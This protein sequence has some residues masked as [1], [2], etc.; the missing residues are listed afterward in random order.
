MAEKQFEEHVYKK[1]SLLWIENSKAMPY[2]FIV[3]SGQLRQ[4]SRIMQSEEVVV[5]NAGDTFGL[6][7]CLTGHEYLNKMEALT[8]TS[9]VMIKQQY[10]IPFLSSKPDIFLKITSDYSNRLRHINQRL[11]TLCSKSLYSEMPDRLLEVAEYFKKKEQYAA[12][13]LALTRYSEYTENEE[14][15]AKAL[16]E[17]ALLKQKG[18]KLFEPQVDGFRAIY[19]RDQIIFLEQERGE[20][21]YF[22]EKGKVKISHIDKDNEFVVAVLK[23][24][25][26]FGEMALL[27]QV[28]RTA[29]AIAFEDTRLLILHRDTFMH[30]VAPQIL[31][32]IFTSLARRIWYSYRRA[33]NLSYSSPVA[34]LYDSLDLIIQSKEGKQKD[35]SYFFDI[36]FQELKVMTNTTECTD[37]ELREFLEDSNIRLGGGSI[38]IV[39]L[40]R[41]EDVYKLHLTREKT[42]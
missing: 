38:A 30:Q 16:Q 12:C 39:N 24:G 42:K 21:F 13:L 23:E 7:E 1:G 34:R 28:A 9:V 40:N 15:K 36:T 4:T 41:F 37:N 29:T 22:I 19:P 20:Q 14:N 26:F 35:I 2:F 11:F 3:K 6:T 31:N 33:L 8:D 17:C 25:E 5:L 32:K 10:V 18:I 27:S